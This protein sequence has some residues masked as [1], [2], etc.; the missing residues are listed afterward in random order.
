VSRPSVIA[1]VVTYRPE[2][3]ALERLLAS[4]LPQVAAVIVVHNGSDPP[5]SPKPR[6]PDADLRVVTLGKNL[7]VARAQNEGVRRAIASGASHVLLLDQDSEPAPDMVAR[8]VEAEDRLKADG[9]KVGALGPRYLDERQD[10]PPPFIQVRGLRLR[11]HGCADPEAVVP[12]DYLVSSGSLIAAD[13]FAAVGDLRDELFI[14]YVDIE[15]GLR[16]AADGYQSFGVCAARMRHS[17]GEAPLR[18]FG[19][20]R[21]VRSPQRHYYLFRN[22]IWLYR[23]RAIP[24]G[25]KCVDG[26]RLW[27]KFLAYGT[28]AK[29]RLEHLR[30]MLR[31]VRDGLRGRLGPYGVDA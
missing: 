3:T 10:N 1:V 23:Q 25:W 4:V 19:R 12:V 6:A 7:G 28:M 16:A 15:W 31:G 5:V 26:W 17:L 18:L 21:P 30:M 9:V 22:A 13:T 27:L 2:P 14:D 20:A 8:L 29:P 11:R 24:V